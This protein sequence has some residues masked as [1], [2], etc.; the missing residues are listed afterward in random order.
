MREGSSIGTDMC[1]TPEHREAISQNGFLDAGSYRLWIDHDLVRVELDAA[2]DLP[3]LIYFL[4]I[5]EEV[6]R[7]HGRVYL[8]VLVG[9]R[10]RPPPPESRRYTAGWQHQH[11]TNGMALVSVRNPVF[12][13]IISLLMRAINLINRSQ[14]PTVFFS[15]ET[16]ARRWL[17]ELRHSHHM[18]GA[19]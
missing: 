18:R 19:A 11:G 1:I 2:L 3:S 13:T 17:N 4:R 12:V 14:R 6:R 9:E 8:L 16:E 10:V 5:I 7:Q 15:T